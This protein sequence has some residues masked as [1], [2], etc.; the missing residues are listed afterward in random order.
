MRKRLVV[1][2]LVVGVCL[3][4]MGRSSAGDV[5]RSDS[6]PDVSL[7]PIKRCRVDVPIADGQRVANCALGRSIGRR[8]EHP[9]A[10]PGHHDAVVKRRPVGDGQRHAR[11]MAQDSRSR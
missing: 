10:Q 2:V 6:P 7:V 4:A 11:S 8:L 1:G 9:E 3:V 5:G